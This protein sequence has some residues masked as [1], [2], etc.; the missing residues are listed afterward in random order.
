[1]HTEQITMNGLLTTHYE[2]PL[3]I[4]LVFKKMQ[5]KFDIG[6]QHSNYEYTN[7]TYAIY[8]VETLYFQN[9]VIF[10]SHMS[11]IF[12]RKLIKFTFSVIFNMNSVIILG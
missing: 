8:F 12:L 3:Y 1:M 11:H 2:R 5:Q 9:S 4:W 6:G 10:E 7:E